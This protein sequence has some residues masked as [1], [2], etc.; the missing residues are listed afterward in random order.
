MQVCLCLLFL[1][2]R[3]TAFT[4]LV[5][6]AAEGSLVDLSL[7]SPEQQYYSK[8]LILTIFFSYLVLKFLTTVPVYQD[9][10]YSKPGNL[11]S[12][13]ESKKLGILHL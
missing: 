3:L 12:E 8:Y 9:V 11:F 10:P 1:P 2:V 7:R 6:L 4:K 13:K 5:R